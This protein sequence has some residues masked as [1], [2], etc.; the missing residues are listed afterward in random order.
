MNSIRTIKEYFKDMI[1][2][3]GADPDCLEKLV[4]IPCTPEHVFTRLFLQEGCPSPTLLSWN[5]T[6]PDGKPLIHVICIGRHL[7]GA[8]SRSLL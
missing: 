1:I 5:L 4:N 2:T 3:L 8:S 7:M 6:M